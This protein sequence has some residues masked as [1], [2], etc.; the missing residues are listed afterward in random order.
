[1][2]LM[3]CLLPIFLLTVVLSGCNGHSDTTALSS[4][5]LSDMSAGTSDVKQMTLTWTSA[6]DDSGVDY[7]VCQ[8]DT[9][10]DYDCDPITAVT[11][12]LTATITVDSLV[13]AVSAEYFILASDGTDIELSNEEM[14][15]ADT[16]TQ[17]IGYVK[18]SNTEA[19][20]AFGYRVA[21]SADGNTLAVGAFLE[22]GDEVAVEDSGAVY[23]FSY[24][25]EHWEQTAYLKADNAG[26]RDYFGYSLALNEDGST[27]AVGAY[28]Q[29]NQS[30]DQVINDLGNYVAYGDG[31][32][33]LYEKTNN[34]WGKTD[35]LQASNREKRDN[36]GWSLALNAS[37]DILAV[38]ANLENS[39]A[40]GVQNNGTNITE[41]NNDANNSGAVYL[42]GKADNYLWEQTTFLKA[43]NSDK[44]DQFGRS[45]ALSSD[46][47]TL[48]VGSF[49]EDNSTSVL[50]ND[51]TDFVSGVEA[52]VKD[53]GAVYLF[54]SDENGNWA[55]DAYIKASNIGASDLFGYSVSL[56]SNGTRLAV[57][58]HHEGSSVNGIVTDITE[59]MTYDNDDAVKSG[60]VY[61]FDY[62]NN[63][64]TQTA[65]IKA[66]NTGEDDR[67]GKAVVLSSDGNTLAVG[68][69]QEDNSISGIVS[70]ISE[71]MNDDATDVGAVYLF[72]HTDGNWEQ[73]AYI[74]ASN[75]EEEDNFGIGLSMN[76]DGSILVVGA[77]HEGTS[78][79]GVISDGS[80]L[81]STR[82]ALNSGAVYIY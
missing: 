18:A 81:D 1:M 62:I 7:V 31:A 49:R 14:L 3:T 51:V 4:F 8:K 77:P 36:F 41:N 5:N 23:L 32:V 42:F 69:N 48:A 72:S 59:Q 44:G 29:N 76:E 34:G 52:D 33:Y 82:D 54:V 70:D 46:G 10:K 6:S 79:T 71:Q 19:D 9:S 15:T 58:A 55:Q 65:Y 74:K 22:D 56:N 68:A 53:Y 30:Y 43:S 40:K 50:D 27:L 2:Q 37:G 11:D 63:S 60:A 13:A 47:K 12:S 75:S 38:G 80:E 16:V 61:M 21:L 24:D 64:W 26:V 39:S 45:V 78:A 57:A 28:N 67:F 17:M 73:S 20:D 35:Y 66:S 25:G